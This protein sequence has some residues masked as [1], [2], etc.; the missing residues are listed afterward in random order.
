MEKKDIGVRGT[1]RGRRRGKRERE[2]REETKRRIR[3]K[4][5][6]IHNFISLLRF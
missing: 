3:E 6:Y 2:R 5:V 1:E 4:L